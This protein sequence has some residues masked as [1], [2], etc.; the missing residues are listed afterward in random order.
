VTLNTH[1]R[2]HH[3]VRVRSGAPV[4]R[5]VVGPGTNY[6]VRT[7]KMTSGN[8]RP[9]FVFEHDKTENCVLLLLLLLLFFKEL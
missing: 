7:Q 8:S 6:C 5:V 1:T 2:F 9:E 3:V 4:V